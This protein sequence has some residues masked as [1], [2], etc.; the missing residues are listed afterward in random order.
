[1][2]DLVNIVCLRNRRMAAMPLV[3]IL[4]FVA[5]DIVDHFV[6]AKWFNC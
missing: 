4:M 3:L 5:Y 6:N 2:S 1:M